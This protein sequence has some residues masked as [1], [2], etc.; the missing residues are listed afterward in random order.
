MAEKHLFV[1]GDGLCGTHVTW[2]D[3]EKSLQHSLNTRSQLGPNKS[4]KDFGDGK[5]LSPKLILVRADWQPERDELPQEFLVKIATQLPVDQIKSKEDGEENDK[6]ENSAEQLLENEALLK[7]SCNVEITVY[8][9]LAKI[10]NGKIKIPKIYAS[11]KFTES[12]PTKGFIIMEHLRGVGKPR[13]LINYTPKQLKQVLRFIAIATANSLNASSEEREVFP[14][15]PFKDIWSSG[16]VIE[17]WKKNLVE[18]RSWGYGKFKGETE[19]LEEIASELFDLNLADGLAEECGMTRVLCH[20]D[21]RPANVLWRLNDEEDLRFCTIIDY[22]R[23]HYGCTATDFVRLFSTAL[24][25]TDRRN[26]WEEL[27]EVFYQYL[28]EEVGDK[29]MP[30]TLQQLKDAYCKFFPTGAALILPFFRLVYETNKHHLTHDPINQVIE[31][32]EC[33]LSDIFYYHERFGK[34]ENKRH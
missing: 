34:Q 6:K 33:L 4:L 11:K 27:L 29:P 20:G 25:G 2:D 21:L 31:K 24:S 14:K 22:Q 1:P 23:A 32:T 10:P 18:L 26:H 28:Q 12:N 9:Q 15:T 16:Y 19:R 30:Y 17:M 5:R 13:T 7:R 8:E 3:L